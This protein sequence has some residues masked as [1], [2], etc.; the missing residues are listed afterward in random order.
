MTEELGRTSGL[1]AGFRQA[2][3]LNDLKEK[4]REFQEKEDRLREKHERGAS[5]FCEEIDRLT[6]ELY[7][8]KEMTSVEL[9]QQKEEYEVYILNQ[10]REHV[11]KI[12]DMLHKHDAKIVE[13]ERVY[14]DELEKKHAGWDTDLSQTREYHE[15]V[16]S[17]IRNDH[18][19]DLTTVCA[20][21]EEKID[22]IIRRHSHESM[23]HHQEFETELNRT[24]AKHA[25]EK[26]LM[27]AKCDDLDR[28]LEQL[29]AQVAILEKERAEKIEAVHQED[30]EKITT[31]EKGLE[32]LKSRLDDSESELRKTIETY[33]KEKKATQSVHSD[34]LAEIKF[35]HRKDLEARIVGWEKKLDKAMDGHQSQV[36]GIEQDHS[37]KVARL[38]MD[39]DRLTREMKDHVQAEEHFKMLLADEKA[40]R[41]NAVKKFQEIRAR[42]MTIEQQ[43][44]LDEDTKER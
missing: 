40:R 5:R 29:E 44:T 36:N 38:I 18:K 4:E 10:E 24:R 12:K 32:S 7:K 43:R 3:T 11:D 6:R 31:M 35:Q 42:L 39:I 33:A 20:Q 37:D 19:K 30:K 8:V 15:R 25:T 41:K 1:E 16:L 34:Q 2:L 22:Q 28:Q 14:T 9:Q 21:Y 17:E 27:T 23:N 13:M 26:E